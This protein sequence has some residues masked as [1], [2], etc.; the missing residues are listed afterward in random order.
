MVLLISACMSI[1]Q[2]TLQDARIRGILS[3]GGIA[4][5][6]DS[7]VSKGHCRVLRR[8]AFYLQGA[9]Q[10]AAYKRILSPKCTSGR[11]APDTFIFALL[12]LSLILQKH[13]FSSEYI[14]Q[15]LHFL[16]Y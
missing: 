2:W 3:A 1:E 16:Q 13:A 5:R 6:C 14:T 10:G 4:G 11:C 7:L 8:E 12:K 9:L 15:C